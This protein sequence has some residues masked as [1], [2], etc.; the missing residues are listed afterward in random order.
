MTEL[1]GAPGRVRLTREQLYERAW[2]T[3]M[4]RLAE[5]FGISGNGLAKICRRLD[6]PYPPRGWWAKKAAGHRVNVVPLPPA[7]PGT[8]VQATVY[9]TPAQTDGVRQAVA[10]LAE[11]V[12]EVPI[13]ERLVRPH[14]IV[15]KWIADHRKRKEEARRERDPWMRSHFSVPDFTEAERRRHRI[16]HTLFRA[17]EKHG[18]SISENDRSHLLA[19]VIGEK[20]EFSC[21]EKSKQITRPLTAEEIRWETWNKSGFKKELEPTG[22][23]EFQ[24]RAWIDQPIRKLWLETERESF[25]TMLLEIVAT[26]LVLGSM[27]AERTRQHVEERRIQEERQRQLELERQRKQQ[28]DNRWSRF[29]QIAESWKRAELAR[30]FIAKLKELDLPES[31]LVDGRSLVEWLDWAEAKAEVRDPVRQ[32]IEATFSD[33]ARVSPWTSFD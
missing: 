27:L 30:E 21:H 6:I 5:Q 20:I 13:P 10:K 8:P 26:F 12:G 14:A 17:L 11:S 24:I 28:D 1:E 18:A 31:E 4:V 23:F 33:L 29:V 16:L 2:Q 25:E 15:A 19:E 32:G 9:A 3:P 22:R 7:R